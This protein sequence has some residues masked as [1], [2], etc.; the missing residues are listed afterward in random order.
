VTDLHGSKWKYNQTLQ[1]SIKYKIDIVINGGDMYPKSGDLF[2]QERFI[3][4]FLDFHFSQ[5][6]AAGIYYLCYPGNDDLK[7]FDPL[8][9]EICLK[10]EHVSN[11]AQR[12]IEIDNYEFVGMNWVVD[13]P[14]R[15]KDRCRM[16][17]DDYIFQKQLGTGI[18]STPEGWK[19]ID[20]WAEY[21]GSLPTIENEMKSLIKPNEMKKAIYVIHMPPAN[22]GLDE[23]VTGVKVGSKAIYNFLREC[24]PLISFHGHIHESPDMSG[25]WYANLNDTLCVQPGQ[26]TPFTYVIIDLETM[27]YERYQENK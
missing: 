7:V 27:N 11:I 20:N 16:D 18:L 1:L 3:L 5:F 15:L 17:T 19:E 10:Y 26:L 22:L 4:E 23:C 12:R 24:Q 2:H 14:F 21:V 13:Y 9:E 6:D 8:F 25:Q